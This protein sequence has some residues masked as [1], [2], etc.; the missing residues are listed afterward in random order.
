[1]DERPEFRYNPGVTTPDPPE[2]NVTL[3]PLTDYSARKEEH[4]LKGTTLEQRSTLLANGRLLVFVAGVGVAW[5]CWEGELAEL[6]PVL[7]LVGLFGLL[8]LIH[9]VVDQRRDS[10]ARRVDYYQA[11]LDRLQHAWIGRGH[12]GDHYRFVDHVY[13][14]DLDVFGRGSLFERLNTACT[15]VGEDTLAGWLTTPGHRDAVICRQEAVRELS[16]EVTLREDLAVACAKEHIEPSRRRLKEWGR[17]E[18][19]PRTN[20][21]GKLALGVTA[22]GAA[23]ALGVGL[24][25]MSGLLLGAWALGVWALHRY[26]RG[27]RGEVLS[28]VSG[29]GEDIRSLL[30][31]LEVILDLE[32]RSTRLTELRETLSR[33]GVSASRILRSLQRTVN[34]RDAQRNQLFAPIGFFLLWDVFLSIA[35]DRW[36]TRFGK[37]LVGWLEAIGEWDALLALGGYAY[38]NPLAVFPT[39]LKPEEGVGPVFRGEDLRHPLLPREQCVP[40]S[41]K[42]GDPASVWMVSGSNMSGKSTLLRTV[43]CNGILALIGAPVHA[44]ALALTPFT[45]GATL[46]IH[47]SLHDGRSRFYAEVQRLGKLLK[48]AA[49]E[50]PLLFLIDEIFHGTNSADR[51]IG[52]QA[53][54]SELVQRGAVGLLTTHDLALAQAAEVAGEQVANVHLRDTVVDGGLVFDYRVHP[55]I[56]THTNALHLMRAVG[57]GV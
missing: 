37:E 38:E 40:N 41:V 27:Y 31:F 23:A 50:R 25:G 57:L 56:L 18:P 53:L 2:R 26:S 52:A 8:A 33:D 55:G 9:V 1:M 4:H 42:L 49:G 51:S 43:G 21:L 32:V 36:R 48:M 47:D 44:T 46:G 15:S 54:I 45:L 7:P 13:V 6:W 24:W 28:G 17:R 10:E 34:L 29:I 20:R 5:G 16:L 12:A 35:I 14:E 3:S 11:G 30:L 19:D 39:L 22:F